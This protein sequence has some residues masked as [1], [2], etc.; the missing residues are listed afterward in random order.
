LQPLHAESQDRSHEVGTAMDRRGIARH[1]RPVRFG[2]LSEHGDVKRA[3]PLAQPERNLPCLLGLPHP[4]G[5]AAQDERL[6]TVLDVVQDRVGGGFVRE[7]G[8]LSR[9]G[10]SRSALVDQATDQLLH[11]C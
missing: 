8:R 6:G 9:L 2:L 5:Q 7:Q 1:A 10:Q 4:V 11:P 3:E